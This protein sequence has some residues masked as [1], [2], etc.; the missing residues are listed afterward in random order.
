MSEEDNVTPTDN[1]DN[2]APST[3]QAQEQDWRLA[4]SEEFR[5]NPSIEKFTTIDGLAK[6]YLNAESMIGRDKIP[7]PQTDDEWADTYPTSQYGA[8][9]YREGMHFYSNHPYMRP[10][11]TLIKD[12]V[13]YEN[14]KAKYGERAEHN[15]IYPAGRCQVAMHEQAYGE[16]NLNNC[17]WNLLEGIAKAAGEDVALQTKIPNAFM[18]FQPM[19]YD[20]SPTN[21]S[22][23][24]A[25]DIFKRGDYVELLAHED[26][27]VAVSLCPLGDQ[28]DMSSKETLTTFP[29]KVK[30]F[31]GAK[32]ALETAPVRLAD[33]RPDSAPRIHSGLTEFDY[34]LGGGIVQGSVTIVG[35]E[36]GIGKS[37]LLLQCAARLEGQGVPVLYVTGE[38]S[39][40]Q[41]RLRADRIEEDAG[42]VHVLPEVRVEAIIERAVE[43][44]AKQEH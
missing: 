18:H 36:P 1:V 10:L 5:T 20:K 11:L 24:S 29:V 34:V 4:M 7:M 30:I 16:E 14:L 33:L 9:T 6:S 44:Y 13:D 27:Y 12:T 23:F 31:E 43:E 38:E 8:L 37:T 40:E 15:F 41:T 19:A 28:H 35:G 32:G 25:K 26:L 42:S 22:L 2:A 21:Y 3:E 39:V 17:D